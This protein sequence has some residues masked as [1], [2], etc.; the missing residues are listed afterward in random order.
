MDDGWGHCDKCNEGFT[1]DY[2]LPT[3]SYFD[4]GYFTPFNK[5]LCKKCY[6]KNWKELHEEYD[7]YQDEFNKRVEQKY[8]NRIEEL[9]GK[10]LD[11]ETFR[12]IREGRTA[13][14]NQIQREFPN[15]F[16][17]KEPNE[18]NNE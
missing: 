2:E 6:P 9:I 15:P 11:D 14:Y 10:S 8:R 4:G 16:T 12:F 3:D 5:T 7:K 18:V 17:E 1:S 13:C